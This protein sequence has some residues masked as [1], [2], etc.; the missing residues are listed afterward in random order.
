MYNFKHSN[1]QSPIQ[2]S[3]SCKPKK[4]IK[5]LLSFSLFS[6]ILSCSSLLLPFI[7]HSYAFSMQFFRYSLN[8]NYMFLVCNGLL[9]FIVKSSGLIGNSSPGSTFNNDTH[10]MKIG[11]N[12]HQ[13]ELKLE[14]TKA[15]TPC[16]EKEVVTP[17]SGKEVVMEVEEEEGRSE[18]RQVVVVKGE[19][20][21]SINQ[22]EGENGLINT[23]DD[24]N[25]ERIESLTTEELNKKCE[26][27]IRRMKEGIKFEAQQLV[28]V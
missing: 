20:E 26:D 4:A 27:F 19:E 9:V 12:I 11:K 18:T 15:S 24:R 28:M 21:L 22:D 5:L 13:T 7:L 25:E 17:C 6:I 14:Q 16:S 2:L 10:A 23:A 8:K 1:I 3:Q